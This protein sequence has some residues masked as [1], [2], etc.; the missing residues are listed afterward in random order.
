MVSPLPAAGITGIPVPPVPE[1]GGICIEPEPAPPAPPLGVE[2]PAT[3]D[4]LLPLAAPLIG[5][6]A[7]VPLTGAATPAPPP[8]PAVTAFGVIGSS[9]LHAA[10]AA[11]VKA[12]RR[13]AVRIPER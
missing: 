11:R 8:E 2:R 9:L 3:A 6:L 7:P 5:L 4:A 12:D 1:A 10:S 13:N